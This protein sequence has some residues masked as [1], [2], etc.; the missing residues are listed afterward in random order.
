MSRS[1][2]LSL[3][4]LVLLNESSRNFVLQAHFSERLSTFCVLCSSKSM[5]PNGAADGRSI[6]HHTFKKD[7]PCRALQLVLMDLHQVLPPFTK[8]RDDSYTGY[9][10]S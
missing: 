6:R 8:V 9:A 2:E 3:K 1:S 7:A 10:S 5:V 4:N